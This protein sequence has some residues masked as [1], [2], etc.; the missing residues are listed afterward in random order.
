[1]QRT[2]GDQRM[3]SQKAA[4]PRLPS[5]VEYPNRKQ[6]PRLPEW[7]AEVVGIALRDTQNNAISAAWAGIRARE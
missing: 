6:S 1:M 3:V 2:G 4:M 5:G 7:N